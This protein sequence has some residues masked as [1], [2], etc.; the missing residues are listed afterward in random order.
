MNNLNSHFKKYLSLLFLITAVIVSNA[1]SDSNK[2]VSHKPAIN[3]ENLRA[4]LPPPVAGST[5]VYGTIKNN[6]DASDTLIGISSNAGMVMLHQSV[7]DESGQA[8]MNHI[9]SYELKPNQQL[10]L[11]PMSYHIMLMNLNHDIVKQDG[12]VKLSFTFKNAGLIEQ[13]IPVIA[14]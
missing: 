5:S 7:V 9:E 6:G 3:F 14:Q 4:I 11:K 2:N 1:Y 8:Q 12:N 13:I 10:I